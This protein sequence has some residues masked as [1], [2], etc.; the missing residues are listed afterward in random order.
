MQTYQLHKFVEK[1]YSNY[2][3]DCSIKSA[4]LENAKWFK[5]IQ[6][7]S[8][9]RKITSRITLTVFNELESMWEKLLANSKEKGEKILKEDFYDFILRI[10]V[11]G[12][13]H[14]FKKQEE[15]S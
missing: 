13:S 6:G 15:A 7:D 8:T 11:S 4:L 12:V 5:R 14:A 10:G 1:A 2:K 3:N 9:K